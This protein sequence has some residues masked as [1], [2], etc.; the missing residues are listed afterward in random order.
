MAAEVSLNLAAAHRPHNH[1]L[2]PG[3]LLVGAGFGAMDF[4]HL[5]IVLKPTT[6]LLATNAG[7]RHFH[8]FSSHECTKVFVHRSFPL[9]LFPRV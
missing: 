6:I 8:R 3:A 1:R 5:L 9:G 4:L 7:T 2:S